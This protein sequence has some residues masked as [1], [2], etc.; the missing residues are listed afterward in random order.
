MVGR[1]KAS[2]EGD[3]GASWAGEP[4]QLAAPLPPRAD[5]R[6]Q[7]SQAVPSRAE[8]VSG[9]NT[10]H[11]PPCQEDLRALICLNPAC[12]PPS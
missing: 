2:P 1:D 3:L 4:Q 11:T 9:G 6:S 7:V 12:R 10:I 8:T 5:L